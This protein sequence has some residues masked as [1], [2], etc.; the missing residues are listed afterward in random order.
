MK[1]LDLYEDLFQYLCRLNRAGRAQAPLE[2]SRVRSEIRDLLDGVSRNAGTDVRLANQAKRLELP[3]IFFIDNLVCTS[4]WSI[5]APWGEKRFAVERG[6]LAGDEKFFDL[7]EQELADPSEEAAER[8]SVLYVCLGL[9]FTGMYVGQPERIRRYIEQIF[10]RVRQ[11]IDSDPRTRISEDAYRFTDTRV[12][13]EPPSNKIVLVA[14]LFVFLS[15]SV[16][17]VYYGLYV[18]AARDLTENIA[19]INKTEQVKR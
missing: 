19:K 13:T 10:P 12:L 2:F 7:L 4:P 6:E 15:L 3:M 16:L 11:W 14:I 9:G 18:K 1:L 17:L 5:A 8:L